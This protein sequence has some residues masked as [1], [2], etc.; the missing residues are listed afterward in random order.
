[1]AAQVGRRLLHARPEFDTS[2][3]LPC[4]HAPG[5]ASPRPHSPSQRPHSPDH[6]VAAAQQAALP[7][8]TPMLQRVNEANACCMRLGLP[9][10]YVLWQTVGVGSSS[11]GGPL[12]L[13]IEVVERLARP[14]AVGSEAG[15]GGTA[16]E[17]ARRLLPEQFLAHHRRLRA[18][19]SS[20]AASASGAAGSHTQRPQT[21][22]RRAGGTPL[23]WL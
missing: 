5:A 8:L 4:Q 15:A 11:T 14:A 19:A 16:H 7:Y 21:H 2:P 9:R 22:Q 12:R 10:R 1:M 6:N 13:C 20:A 17:L 23:P 3:L 18:A